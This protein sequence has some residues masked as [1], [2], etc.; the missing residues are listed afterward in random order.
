[1]AAVSASTDASV[2]KLRMKMAPS[3]WTAA[4]WKANRSRAAMPEGDGIASRAARHERHGDLSN[5]ARRGLSSRPGGRSPPR[6]TSSRSSLAAAAKSAKSLEEAMEATKC[7]KARRGLKLAI[8]PKYLG[9]PRT[10]VPTHTRVL[11]HT[12]HSSLPGPV[13]LVSASC[14]RWIHYIH[15]QHGSTGIID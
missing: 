1:M 2:M 13:C 5:V 12:G 14:M 6:S 8:E 15:Q 7:D 9:R 4:S 11:H 10:L 3:A